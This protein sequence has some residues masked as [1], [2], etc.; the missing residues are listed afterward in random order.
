MKYIWHYEY[1]YHKSQVPV[2]KKGSSCVDEPFLYQYSDKLKETF[3][4]RVYQKF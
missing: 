2:Y 1:V 4:R 3:V